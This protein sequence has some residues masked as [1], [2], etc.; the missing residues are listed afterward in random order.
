[1]AVADSSRVAGG[2]CQWTRR[3]AADH[4]AVAQD[5]LLRLLGHRPDVWNGRRIRRVTG[6]V[7]HAREALLVL[8][9][10]R[11]CPRLVFDAVGEFP[12]LV[13]RRAWCPR[14]HDTVADQQT[15][16]QTTDRLSS[17]GVM[18]VAEF[19]FRHRQRA[20]TIV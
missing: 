11:E 20:G 10:P 14:L 16:G 13:R 18:A 1:R 8:G 15:A 5:D 6:T 2:H 3:G 17:A 19:L 7:C 4:A 12:G 9:D